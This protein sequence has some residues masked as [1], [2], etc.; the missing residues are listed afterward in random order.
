MLDALS[1]CD[2]PTFRKEVIAV[3]PLPAV[4]DPVP[5]LSDELR[6]KL[7]TWIEGTRPV[8]PEEHEIEQIRRRQ[9]AEMRDDIRH[10]Y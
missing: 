9:A 2:A 6:Q 10:I 4:P 7:W 8:Y 5:T 1:C 3:E